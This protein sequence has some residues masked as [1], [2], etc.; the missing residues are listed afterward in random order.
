[1][2]LTSPVID[3]GARQRLTARFGSEVGRWFDELPGLLTALAG[4]WQIELGSPIPRG[5]AS[6]V[7]RCHMADG[8]PAVLKTSPDRSRLALEASALAVW[9]TV[10][11]PAVIAF[12]EQVG[13]LLLEAIEP[14]MPL[15]VTS[16]YPTLDDVAGLLSSLHGQSVPGASYPPV[17]QRVDNLFRSSAKLYERAPD[18]AALVPLDLY[19]RGHALATRLARQKLPIVPLHGDLTPRNILDGG[20]RG[21]VAIDPTPCVGDAAFDAV[22]LIL[23]QAND[24]GTI[25]ARTQRL[26]AATGLDAE[27]LHDWCCAFAGMVALELAS[28]GNTPRTWSEAVRRLA[29]QAGST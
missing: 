16:V 6:A 2:G 22:D 24:L 13:A 17:A 25:E 15:I 21:L 18:L 28:E 1:M 23:W 9:D 10:H 26:A 4:R 12:D 5:T 7:F 19:E 29:S 3:P 8:R 11:T 14:G 27:R 20:E